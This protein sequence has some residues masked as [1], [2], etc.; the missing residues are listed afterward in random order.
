[1]LLFKNKL[2]QAVLVYL[3]TH[4]I[5][6]C[7]STD[8]KPES[9]APQ[10][11]GTTA[12]LP[13]PPPVQA[14]PGLKPSQRFS[15]ALRNLELGK[16]DVALAELKAYI[17][18]K[19]SSQS[20]RDLIN[21]IESP[22]E[23]YYPE[24]HFVVELHSGESLSTLAKKYLGSALDFYSL[25]KYNGLTN[26]NQVRVGQKV[27]IPKTKRSQKIHT[28]ITQERVS[29]PRPIKT[30]AESGPE[31]GYLS[32]D[33]DEVLTDL[34]EHIEAEEQEPLRDPEPSPVVTP[35]QVVAKIIALNQQANYLAAYEKLTQLDS[36]AEHSNSILSN[37]T[38][39]DTLSGYAD[40]VRAEDA[41]A[42]ATAYKKVSE[43]YRQQGDEISQYLYLAKATKSKPSDQGLLNQTK[44][45]QKA[46]VEKYHR[47]ASSQFRRQELDQAIANWDTVLKI[48]PSHDNAKV[49][50]AQA[51]ELKEK[52]KR[53]NN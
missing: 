16:P 14:E 13:S 51:I 48:A 24:E 38:R 50:R 45:M 53:L 32:S 42:A 39:L 44:A 35:E 52:L 26:A 41:A 28:G 17:K 22:I 34:A 43:L 7:T 37:T 5:H 23:N 25:A 31:E 27:K 29:E 33:V 18:A 8:S 9:V 3:M 36:I 1:M 46:L 47:K 4:F 12:P 2:S 20:A 10:Q 11:A 30:P 19:P 40:T 49:F 21:Q 6:G 15:K